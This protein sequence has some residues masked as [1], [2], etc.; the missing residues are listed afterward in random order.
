MSLTHPDGHFL[1]VNAALCQT[2][3]YTGYELLQRGISDVTHP[4]DM[5]SDAEQRLQLLSGQCENYQLEKRNL[6]KDGHVVYIRMPISTTG[7]TRCWTTAG[8]IPTC[9]NSS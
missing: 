8:S 2:L 7:W 3:G 1:R 4:D 9:S 5:A 6:H